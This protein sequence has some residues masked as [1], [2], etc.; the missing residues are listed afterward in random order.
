M[1]DRDRRG[2]L[3]IASYGASEG[4]RGTRVAPAPAVVVTAAPAIDARTSLAT[5]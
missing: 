4:G 3:A 2:R 5:R 1:P